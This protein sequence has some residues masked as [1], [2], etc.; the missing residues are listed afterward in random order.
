MSLAIGSKSRLY[1]TVENTYGVSPASNVWKGLLFSTES[2]VENINKIQS[3]DIRADRTQAAIRAGNI[4]VGGSV[5]NDFA[6][7]RFGIWLSHL[8]C[9][10]STDTTITVSPG[11]NATQS[12]G[13]ASALNCIRGQPFSSGASGSTGLF[14]AAN[15]FTFN[16]LGSGTETEFV[17]D[18]AAAVAGQT[19]TLATSSVGGTGQVF[20]IVP[21]GTATPAYYKHVL[22][23]GATKPAVGLSIE[24]QVLGGTTSYFADFRGVRINTLGLTIPQ[25]GLIK[26]QWGLLGIDTVIGTTTVDGAGTGYAYPTDD[27]QAGYDTFVSLNGGVTSRPIKEATLEISNNYDESVYSLSSQFRTDITEGKRMVTTKVTTY[28]SDLT[29]YNLFK[30]QTNFDM[31]F[32][33]IHGGGVMVIDMPENRFTGSGTPQIN[34]QGVI[35]CSFDG[36]TFHQNGAYDIQITVF[37]S[38]ATII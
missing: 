3:E 8:L 18:V 11:G 4:G 31:S 2:L 38:N 6:L 5:S 35:T 1:W 14:V 30:N 24:K 32:T 10:T 33:T 25:G 20:C 7:S 37:D 26:A 29:E 27:P 22:T 21:A 9:T 23:A 12:T 28:F 15:S 16:T 19:V 17:A 13:Y 36:S 34:G